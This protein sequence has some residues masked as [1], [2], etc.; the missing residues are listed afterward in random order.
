MALSAE[1]ATAL[2]GLIAADSVR[3]DGRQPLTDPDALPGV[4]R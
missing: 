4:I 2:R 3:V 1:S